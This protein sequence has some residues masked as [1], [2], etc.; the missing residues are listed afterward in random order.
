MVQISGQGETKYPFV[1]RHDI[2]R[3]LA[4]TLKNPA[5]FENQWLELA[6]DIAQITSDTAASKELKV[7]TSWQMRRMA[8]TSSIRVCRLRTFPLI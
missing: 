2:G 8:A 7:E 4:H 5:E 6:N 1:V 3:V